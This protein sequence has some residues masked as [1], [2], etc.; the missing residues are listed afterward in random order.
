MKKATDRVSNLMKSLTDQGYSEEIDIEYDATH[1]S[2]KYEID[3]N[4]QKWEAEFDRGCL[5]IENQSQDSYMEFVLKPDCEGNVET[6]FSDCGGDI[7]EDFEECVW[8][9][10]PDS[11]FQLKKIDPK[12]PD[13]WNS[14]QAHY[15]LDSVDPEF[16]DWLM[17]LDLEKA[18]A[19]YAA[20]TNEGQLKP[21]LKF[22]S[23]IEGD[24]KK[25]LARPSL[26]NAIKTSYPGMDANTAKEISR[27]AN[28]ENPDIDRIVE[29]WVRHN[30]TDYEEDLESR[31]L[32]QMDDTVAKAESRHRI[33]SE[34]DQILE[35]WRTPDTGGIDKITPEVEIE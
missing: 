22:V 28:P 5:R 10:I 16:D 35:K 14:T 20:R 2:G 25:I 23:E 21:R 8:A 29:A 34:I 7:P 9:H 3:I 17:T 33:R 19:E 12:N 15:L 13:T 27:S 4:G 26:S 18:V 32:G 24:T 31:S 11:V 6:E 30:L 1:L